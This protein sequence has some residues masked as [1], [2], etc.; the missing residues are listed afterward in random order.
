MS[1]QQAKLSE[2][3]MKAYRVQGF[4]CANCAAMFENNVKELPWC[5]GCKS[6][7]WSI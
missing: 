3:E 7:F 6:K 2:E 4:T 5:S 1:E